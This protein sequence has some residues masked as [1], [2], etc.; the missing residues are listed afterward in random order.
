ME[1]MATVAKVA[2]LTD[3]SI[4]QNYGVELDVLVGADW[5]PCQRL[6]RRLRHEEFEAL[7]TFSRAD[8]P[9]GRQLVVFLSHLTPESAVRV[10]R[11]RRI[12]EAISW[13]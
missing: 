11:V 8:F 10:V 2:D 13:D 5:K 7:W 9:R 1:V 4:R 6:A 3:S 12:N